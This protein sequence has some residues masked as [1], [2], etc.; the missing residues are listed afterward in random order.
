MNV[1]DIE[2]DDIEECVDRIVN[3]FSRNVLDMDFISDIVD[4]YIKERKEN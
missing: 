2:S 4:E 3:H 1:K